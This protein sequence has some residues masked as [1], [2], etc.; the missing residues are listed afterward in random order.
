[1][2]KTICY[3]RTS[4]DKQDINN[5]KL[6]I[7]EFARRCNLKIEDF[8][9]IEVIASTRK[10]EKD[11][12]IDE[13]LSKLSAGDTLIVTELSRLNRTI[14]GIIT[15]IDT[16]IKKEV[17]VIVLKERLN[18]YKQDINSRIIITLFGM[19]AELERHLIS[20]RTKEALAKK[21]ATGKLLGKPK[22]IVQKSI[23]DEHAD[24]IKEL[25]KMGLSIRKIAKWLNFK[26]FQSLDHYVR[27]KKLREKVN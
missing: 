5:Q 12:R 20:E 8:E 24:K 11:R 3:I 16:L 14:V 7:Y 26:S 21:K 25:L 18:L 9:F 17:N 6:E 1:M 19:F 15:L 27:R 2:G 22:G 10:S 23:F 4:T 13:L